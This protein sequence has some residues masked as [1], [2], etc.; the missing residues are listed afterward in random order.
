MA[1]VACLIAH[2]LAGSAVG[3]VHIVVGDGG[4]LIRRFNYFTGLANVGGDGDG[5]TSHCG[6]RKPCA[7]RRQE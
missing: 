6:Y 7:N 4:A 5:C 1:A 3:A 2:E